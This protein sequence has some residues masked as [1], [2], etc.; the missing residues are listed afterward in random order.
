MTSPSEAANELKSFILEHREATEKGRRTAPPIIEKLKET[1]LCRLGLPRS[2]GGWED[3]ADEK[4]RR[5]AAMGSVYG[6]R[7][8]PDRGTAR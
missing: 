5:R 3:D 1:K 8:T 7:E 6:K 4:Q 2:L